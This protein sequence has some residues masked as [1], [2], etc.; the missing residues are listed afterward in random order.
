MRY[1]TFISWRWS[2]EVALHIV[3]ISDVGWEVALNYFFTIKTREL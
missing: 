1:I 3:P 2:L